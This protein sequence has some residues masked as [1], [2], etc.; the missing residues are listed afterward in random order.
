MQLLYLLD[1]LGILQSL[2]F[3]QKAEGDR[4]RPSRSS[5]K[6]KKLNQIRLK[7]SSA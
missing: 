6:S 1:N 2:H 7:H 3:L 4:V 5:S